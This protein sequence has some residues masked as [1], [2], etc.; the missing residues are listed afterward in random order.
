MTLDHFLAIAGSLSLSL[1]L[2]NFLTAGNPA[3]LFFEPMVSLTNRT[4]G[5]PVCPLAISAAISDRVHPRYVA[6]DTFFEFVAD[7]RKHPA[8]SAFALTTPPPDEPFWA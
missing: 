2:V 1:S 8:G 4:M 6:P 5:L 3:P 7:A